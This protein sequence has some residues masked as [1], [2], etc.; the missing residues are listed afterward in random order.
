[1]APPGVIRR[2]WAFER[3]VVRNHRLRLDPE[4]RMRRFFGYASAA[5]IAAHCERLDWSRALVVGHVMGGEV[6][7]LGQLEPVGARRSEQLVV[8]VRWLPSLGSAGQAIPNLRSDLSAARA[9][10]VRTGQP[11]FAPGEP[12][13]SRVIGG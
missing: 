3:D 8:A 11:K 10:L 2:P 6:C 7:G 13:M 4:D 1:M 9:G 12:G 5:R